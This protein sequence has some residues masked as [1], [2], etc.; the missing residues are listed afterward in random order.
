MRS[1]GRMPG[2]EGRRLGVGGRAG[3]LGGRLAGRDD[4][5]ATDATMA[6]SFC[7]CD[8]VQGDEPGEQHD[9]DEEVHHRAAH[10]D[11]DLLGHRE[12]VEDAV[13]VAGLDLLEA[14]LAGLVGELGEPAGA[15]HPQ[16]PGLVAGPRREHA[17]HPDVAAERDGLDAV[18]G[19][20]ALRDHT[21]GPKPTMYWVTLTPN[22]LAG[23]R[24][25]ISCSPID[26]PTPRTTKSTPSTNSRHGHQR[27]A[28]S[29]SRQRRSVDRPVCRPS[30]V[31]GPV[32]RPRV[33]AH[34]VLNGQCP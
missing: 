31:A 16:R 30:T 9:G 24:W 18:L 10:H 27:S 13:L 15:R 20:A 1:P 32:A 5:L 26:R 12:L 22:F 6:P 11:D 21:V 4:A 29:A 14:E 17:D 34:H 19:L 3:G 2:G 33:G 7:T 25:P 8:A 23:T 28:P